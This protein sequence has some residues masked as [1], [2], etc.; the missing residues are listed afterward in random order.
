M[1][2]K[3]DTNSPEILMQARSGSNAPHDWIVL[4]LLRNKLIVGMVGWIF[5]ALMG[6]GLF[7]LLASIV[8]PYNY[9]HG[10][11]PAIFS[12]ILLG[13]LLFIGLGSAWALLTDIRRLQHIG[14]HIIVITPD[15]FV[16]QEGDKIINVPLMY[17]RH[18]TTRGAAPPNASY[19]TSSTSSASGRRSEAA[20]HSS[21]ESMGAFFIGRGFTPS[22][23][24]W[25]RKRMRTPTSLAF[26]DSR[27][28][29]E[30]T[31]VTDGAYGD[32]FMIAALLKQYCKAAQSIV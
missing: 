27:D 7:A 9:E 23:A 25:R 13:I 21:G 8:I 15:T 17:V 22:G 16:K 2:M 24:N 19:D 3:M 18:V 29:S 6:L 10:A 28:D 14:Q 11:F 30:V 26:V 20:M 31:V 12:T 1:E 5:G 4:P 32:P